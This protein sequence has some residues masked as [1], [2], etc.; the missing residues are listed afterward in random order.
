MIDWSSCPDVE[1]DTDR[2]SARRI[3]VVVLSTIS[4]PRIRIA[5]EHV[6][7]A[8]NLASIGSY[9]PCNHGYRPSVIND[10]IT[11]SLIITGAAQLVPR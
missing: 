8:I 3:A 7:S 4:W 5:V 9:A 11:L 1:R 2:V 10:K 6:A